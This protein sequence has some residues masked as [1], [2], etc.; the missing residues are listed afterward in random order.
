M[1]VR[2][3]YCPSGIPSAIPRKGGV[4]PTSSQH[5]G[6][7]NSAILTELQNTL[8]YFNLHDICVI[9]CKCPS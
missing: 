9:H 8:I 6:D 3:H 4:A 7:E 5:P 2:E 1:P